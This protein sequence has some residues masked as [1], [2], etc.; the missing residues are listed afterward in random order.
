[1]VARS[2]DAWGVRGSLPWSCGRPVVGPRSIA[3]PELSRRQETWANAAA[4]QSIHV[5]FS[6]GIGPAETDGPRRAGRRR[7]SRLARRPLRNHGGTGCSKSSIGDGTQKNRPKGSRFS[8]RLLQAS[9][10]QRD[11]WA[12]A[13]VRLEQ[14]PGLCGARRRKPQNTSRRLADAA[15][16]AVGA[17][18]P[19]LDRKR[20]RGRLRFGRERW[21]N[22]RTE[23][24]KTHPVPP[25]SVDY[26][27]AG[28]SAD[29]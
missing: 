29:R 15:T 17:P 21:A 3:S 28:R 16:G 24:P 19:V 9:C 20:S 12:N 14:D 8:A 11:F 23:R 1:M 7:V 25:R 26:R 10:A 18:L 4:C 2:R 22:R 6:S 13:V 27:H 5:S